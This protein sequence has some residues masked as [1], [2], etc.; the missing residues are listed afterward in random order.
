MLAVI[1]YTCIIY[2]LYMY[3]KLY[4]YCI[5]GAIGF[6]CTDSW[7]G[8]NSLYTVY[9]RCCIQV[10]FPSGIHTRNPVETGRLNLPGFNL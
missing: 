5:D 2:N 4:M 1:I 10:I 9:G 8:S 3:Y 7:S 6:I